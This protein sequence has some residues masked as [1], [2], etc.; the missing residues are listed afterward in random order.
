MIQ[1]PTL[2]CFAQS[3]VFTAPTKLPETKELFFEQVILPF[4]Q[5]ATS[6]VYSS[7]PNS[8]PYGMNWTN[9]W[10]NSTTSPYDINGTTTNNL[11]GICYVTKSLALPVG[12][13]IEWIYYA[14]SR[15][16]EMSHNA[17][18]IGPGVAMKMSDVKYSVLDPS[19]QTV[20]DA[21]QQTVQRQVDQQA[22][23]IIPIPEDVDERIMVEVMVYWSRKGFLCHWLANR[24][25]IR[26]SGDYQDLPAIT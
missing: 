15:A 13:P 24:L 26:K 4:C 2:P 19:Q 1:Q 11:A 16:Q 9:S 14:V 7:F 18:I 20:Y 6:Q 17:F 8:I 23:P 3:S 22:R 5:Q 12:T 25:L 10:T 21:F